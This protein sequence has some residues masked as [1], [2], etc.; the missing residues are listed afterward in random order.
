MPATKRGLAA[1][2]EEAEA[3]TPVA[4]KTPAVAAGRA[5]AARGAAVAATAA[6]R[7]VTAGKPAAVKGLAAA[8]EGTVAKTLAAT[9]EPAPGQPVQTAATEPEQRLQKDN[10]A[11]GKKDACQYSSVGGQDSKDFN[12]YCVF[13]LGAQNIQFSKTDWVNQSITYFI[14]LGFGKDP[15]LQI[16]LFLFF[17]II[18]VVTI[19]GN[20]LIAGLVISDRHLHRPMYYFLANLS[21]LE[22][23]YTSIILPRML[24]S[25]LTGDRTISV[26]GCIVQFN[27]FSSLTATECYLLAVMSYDRYLAIRRPLHYATLMK[28]RFCFQLATG[29]WVSGFL[30]STATT[31]LLSKFNF[32]DSNEIDHFFCDFAPL[33]KLSCSD[34]TLMKLVTFV[35]S[36]IFTLPCFV[37][38]VASYVYIISTILKIPSTKGRQKA[39]STCS[40]HLMVVTIFYGT[41]IIVYLLPDSPT[42]QDLNKVLSLFYTVL[43]PMINPLIYSLRNKDVQEAL[44][45]KLVKFLPF[46]GSKGIKEGFIHIH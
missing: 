2:K 37:L 8:A 9:R 11:F 30:A 24:A 18:Y 39:F 43:T 27:V 4:A 1:A 34:T 25:F 14:L 45:K 10:V 23:C 28:G 46:T 42:L 20:L 3:K 22:T 12:S 41:L 13:S 6:G 31:S 40:S 33:L 21:S 32:C 16:L 15:E 44:K 5:A 19:I 36:V 38:T 17:L 35:L 26:I 29:S 7:P